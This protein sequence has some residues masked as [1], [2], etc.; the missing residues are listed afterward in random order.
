MQRTNLR[1]VALNSALRS[2]LPFYK[3]ASAGE[4]VKDLDAELEMWFKVMDD[5]FALDGDGW[6]TVPDR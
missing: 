3:G 6:F 4:L 2:V 1:T 5:R